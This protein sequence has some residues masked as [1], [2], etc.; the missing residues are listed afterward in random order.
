MELSRTHSKK[1]YPMW[2]AVAGVR[3]ERLVQ[4]DSSGCAGKNFRYCGN[5]SVNTSEVLAA[6]SRLVVLV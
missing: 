6:L 5:V 3:Y 1:D 4:P 2:S